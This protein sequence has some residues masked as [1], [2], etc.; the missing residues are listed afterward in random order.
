MYRHL[1]GYRQRLENDL[2][3]AIEEWDGKLIVLPNASHVEP[4]PRPKLERRCRNQVMRLRFDWIRGDGT[5]DGMI[6]AKTLRAFQ[7]SP[8]DIGID[9]MG[10]KCQ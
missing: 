7:V 6:K 2:R 4:L 1:P 10:L 9:L 5:Y 3:R 8:C